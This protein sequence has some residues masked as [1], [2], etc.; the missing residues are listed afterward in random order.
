[1]VMNQ[2]IAK[3]LKHITDLLEA[4]GG[5]EA[6]GAGSNEAE[7]MVGSGKKHHKKHHKKNAWQETVTE[8]MKGHKGLIPKKGTPQYE[9]L[10]AKYE[11]KK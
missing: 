6:K 11:A 2:E 4:K 3:H 1:M 7:E 10:R 8:Y 9:E 5:N